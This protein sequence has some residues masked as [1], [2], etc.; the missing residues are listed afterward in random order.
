MRAAVKRAIARGPV[1]LST[2][3]SDGTRGCGIIDPNEWAVA[4]FGPYTGSGYT[5]IL[6][7]HE[8]K[9]SAQAFRRHLAKGRLRTNG[10]RFILLRRQDDGTWARP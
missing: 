7:V 9:A 1:G 6:S 2:Y 8:T 3:M 10:A 5:E 4:E